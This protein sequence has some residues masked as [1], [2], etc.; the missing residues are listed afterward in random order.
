MLWCRPFG[1]SAACASVDG[2]LESRGRYP[3]Y[4]EEDPSRPLTSRCLKR[5]WRKGPEKQNIEGAR[6]GRHEE[7][8]SFR[9][10]P[11][12]DFVVSFACVVFVCKWLEKERNL[13]RLKL[14]EKQEKGKCKKTNFLTKSDSFRLCWS[15][16]ASESIC[17]VF[18]A[19]IVVRRSIFY[20]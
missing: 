3:P 7:T 14:F 8:R 13:D 1:E 10:G 15:C 6:R 19:S 5:S 17:A 18:S 9:F 12:I 20:I 4:R 11:P 16:D 2:L